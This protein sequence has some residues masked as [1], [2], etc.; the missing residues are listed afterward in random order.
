MSFLSRPRVKQWGWVMLFGLV[1]F[2]AGN[3]HATE[4]ALQGS[5]RWWQGQEMQ[6]AKQAW[7]SAQKKAWN[8][9]IKDLGTPGP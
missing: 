9:C 7:T 4:D 6:V 8:D 3:Y 2:G 1:C 5:A